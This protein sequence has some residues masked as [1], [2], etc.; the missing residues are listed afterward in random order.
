MT[1]MDLCFRILIHLLESDP[2]FANCQTCCKK[3][4]QVWQ[5]NTTKNIVSYIRH[6]LHFAILYNNK[7]KYATILRYSTRRNLQMRMQLLQDISLLKN[8]DIVWQRIKQVFIFPTHQTLC[9]IHNTGHSLNKCTSFRIKPIAFRKKIL[10]DKGICFECCTGFHLAANCSNLISCEI[11]KGRNHPTAL[12]VV[13][14]S[15]RWQKS[16]DRE[17]AERTFEVTPYNIQKSSHIVRRYV[18]NP[19]QDNHVQKRCQFA[20]IHRANHQ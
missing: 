5:L 13:S 8:R 19:S 11:Y 16:H 2:L 3:N 10:K 4:G 15:H 9:P 17:Q 20:C 1:C 12:H 18:V 14:D 6:F 7:A